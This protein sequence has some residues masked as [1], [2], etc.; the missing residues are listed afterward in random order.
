MNLKEEHKPPLGVI[1]YWVI[2]ENRIEELANAI[3]RYIGEKNS[4]NNIKNYAKEII[5][6]CSLIEKMQEKE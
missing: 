5:L 6:Y 4:V 2:A 3:L 1:P